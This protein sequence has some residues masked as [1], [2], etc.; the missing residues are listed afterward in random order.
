MSKRNVPGQSAIKVKSISAH[1]QSLYH[2]QNYSFVYNKEG[3][4]GYLVGEQ[5]IPA[6]QFEKAVLIPL[7]KN[8][9]MQNVTIDPRHII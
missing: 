6:K 8:Q 5:I 4:S 1:L 9:E 3:Q 2:L 7:L